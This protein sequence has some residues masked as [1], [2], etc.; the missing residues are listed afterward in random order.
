MHTLMITSMDQG[1]GFTED[2]LRAPV[3]FDRT[4]AFFTAVAQLA[5]RLRAR[6][7]AATLRAARA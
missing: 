6:R 1:K 7:A 3:A 5:A 2:A 4:V